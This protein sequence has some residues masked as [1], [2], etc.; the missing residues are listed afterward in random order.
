MGTPWDAAAPQYLEEWVPRIV[1]YHLDLVREVA[2]GRGARVWVASAGPGSE[3]LAAARAVGP[4]GFVRATDKSEVMV[5][6]C[7]ERVA[8]AGFGDWV[9]CAV[10]DEDEDI[11]PRETRDDAG[12]GP[13]GSTPARGWDAVLCAFGLWQLASPARALAAWAR[14]LAPE[15][16]LGVLTWGPREPGSPFDVLRTSLAEIAPD[17]AVPD[18]SIQAEREPMGAMFDAAGLAM[19]RHTRVR[20]TLTFPTTE[21]FVRAMKA[22]CCWQ[23]VEGALGAE[24]FERVLVR[25]CE[26][27]GGP[28]APLA[29]EPPAT[30]AIGVKLGE[31]GEP[32]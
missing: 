6:L 15:G 30:L 24:R 17:L 21:A 14:T 20:H 32:G 18:P 28:R 3:V 16:K 31:S 2:L 13:A 11:A 23:K 19:V 27:F 29:F 7:R 5:H 12:R 1:P 10:G 22:G 26:S 4:S 8:R 25:F 9:E